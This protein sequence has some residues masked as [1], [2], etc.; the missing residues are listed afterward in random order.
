LLTSSYLGLTGLDVRTL[1]VWTT[2]FFEGLGWLALFVVFLTLWRLDAEVDLPPMELAVFT[3]GLAAGF[4]WAANVIGMVA[5]ASANASKLFFIFFL[6]AGCS[7]RLH[8][9]LALER[10]QVR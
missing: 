1:A 4:V 5:T 7:A 6:P 2:P 8:F 3:A 9:H 10:P